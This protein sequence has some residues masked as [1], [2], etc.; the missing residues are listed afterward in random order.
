MFLFDTHRTCL[1]Q[2]TT[3]EINFVYLSYSE[4]IIKP[5][6]LFHIKSTWLKT[7]LANS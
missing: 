5:K 1:I 3:F 7:S 2:V 6:R 4:D